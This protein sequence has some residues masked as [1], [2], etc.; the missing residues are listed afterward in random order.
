MNPFNAE[1][2][3][4]IVGEIRSDEKAISPTQRNSMYK[5]KEGMGIV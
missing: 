5:G 4:F 1:R 2:V 3:N